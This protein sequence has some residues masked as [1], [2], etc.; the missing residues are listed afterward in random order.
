MH[1]E[2][3]FDELMQYHHAAWEY[4]QKYGRMLSLLD[5]LTKEIT[6]QYAAE[7][8]S[9]YARLFAICAQM[10]YTNNGAINL[11]RINAIKVRKGTY[12][13][14][15]HDYLFDLKALAEFISFTTGSNVPVPLR[16]MLPDG[17]R[18][19]KQS[20]TVAF[21]LPKIRIVV[22]KWD[23]N[24]VYGYDEEFPQQQIR[25]NYHIGDSLFSELPQQLFAGVQLNLLNVKIEDEIYYPQLIVLE[26]DYLIDISSLSACKELYGQLPMNYL[27]SKLMPNESTK[28]T[29]LGNAANQFL[30]DCVNEQHDHLATYQESVVKNFRDYLLDY[31]INPDINQ[32]F[33]I[34]AQKQFKNIHD[35][36][37]DKFGDASVDI[38][39]HEA[40]LEPSFFCE[41]LGLQGRIDL[42]LSDFTRIIELK[43]GKCEEKGQLHLGKEPHSLQMALYK[44]ILH[45]NMGIPRDK[46]NTFLFYSR[47]P[48]LFEQRN[49]FWKIQEAIALRNSIVHQERLIRN[50]KALELL[51][52][53]TPEMLNQYNLSGKLWDIYI[54]PRLHKFLNTF[55]IAT[56]LE[57]TYFNRLMQFTQIEQFLSKMGDDQPDSG[58]GFAET[59]QQ[60]LE[61]KQ[62][63]GNILIDLTIKDF[64]ENQGI[65]GIRM[66]FPIYDDCFLPNFREGDTVILYERNK[67]SD[68][69]TNHI[70]HRCRIEQLDSDSILLRLNYKQR[71]PIVFHRD[72]MYALEHDHMDSSNVSIY[73]GLYNFLNTNKERRDLLLCQR[74]PQTDFSLQLNGNYLNAVINRIVLQAKQAKDYFLLV[75]PPG[76]GKTSVTIK[77]MVEE[78]YS[79]PQQ[80]ILLLSYTNRAVDELCKMLESINPAPA[81]L[82]IGSELNCE[83][84]F[85]CNLMKNKAANCKNR[86]DILALFASHRIIVGTVSSITG[87]INSLLKIKHFNVAIIDEASQILETQLLGILS[88]THENNQCCVDKFIMVGDHKQLPAVVVQRPEQSSVKEDILQQIGLNDCR[89]SLFERLYNWQ[90]QHPTP[91]IT[92]TLLRQGRM[93]PEVGKFANEHF[94]HGKLLPVPLQ[95]QQAD[96]E[97]KKHGRDLQEYVATTRMGFLHCDY[98]QI[99]ENNKSNRGEAKIVAALVG[100]IHELCKLNNLPFDAYN[101]IGIIVP[102]RGQISMVRQELSRLNIP[103]TKDITIDTVE[104]FQGSQR[105]II[106]F[107]TTISQ[108]YQLDILSV[109]V[110]IEGQL[111]D[112]KLNVALTRAKKQLFIVGNAKLLERDEIYKA[113]IKF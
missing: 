80:Q 7:Y 61:T 50:G 1:A 107:T 52:N 9:L 85:R 51:T 47:Y 72:S 83:K 3:Y 55:H 46:V 66:S 29:L 18:E 26:P 105:D 111:V 32:D 69:A 60:D 103:E 77:S 75:G 96:I 67:A 56:E 57:N 43:S 21:Q 89:N 76:T 13:P 23:E 5:R 48:H 42:M 20:A 84:P 94:Y 25:V 112:R 2:E 10:H 71:N 54:Q 109:P 104:R 74:E 70:V 100:T 27:I 58:R 82:R 16:K 92:A 53:T 63:N 11:F 79:E 15:E 65:E 37:K 86:K 113:L 98:P 101:R 97:F 78:F 38:N 40:L 22:E 106:I 4:P 110:M 34:E 39:T 73:R 108:P 62:A 14:N 33:F 91:N 28:Y 87:Q 68:L 8:T 95:H 88:A 31:S 44:E 17:W 102:F 81:Y 36:V 99:E 19:F 59:W 90:L 24:Y 35:T 6:R 45:Y 93:H 64:I 30:D 41:A 49:S 12:S